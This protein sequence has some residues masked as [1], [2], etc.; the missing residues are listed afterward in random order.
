[1]NTPKVYI[2][3]GELF[4]KITIL[5]IKLEKID[6]KK[7]LK[8][9]KKEYDELNL[10]FLD[11]FS[12]NKVAKEFMI[13]L[14]FINQKLWDIEDLI[15]EKEKNNSFDK[16]F[17]ELARKVYFTNDDRSLIKRKINECFGSEFIE[18]KLYSD[19]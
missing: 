7:A 8:N 18:E 19:Y 14:K 11:N 4:D 12:I 10:I 6:S 1:M 16:Y 17:I 5:Q 15:R 2:S 3:W 13:E 9:I